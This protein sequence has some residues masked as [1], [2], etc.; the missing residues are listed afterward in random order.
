MLVERMARLRQTVDRLLPERHI[1]LGSGDEMRSISLSTRRQLAAVGLG[2]AVMVWAVG[3]TLGVAGGA[4]ALSASEQEAVQLK[5]R[6]QRLLADRQARLDQAVAQLSTT[7]G[8]VD[9]LAATVESRHEAL[10]KVMTELK[11]EPGAAEALEVE[12]SEAKPG[13][14]PAAR[15][16]RV[17]LDQEALMAKADAFART[18]AERLKLALRMA[19][20]GS[21]GVARTGVSA[22]GGP[23]VDAKD[24]RALAAIL[25]VDE[26]F[27]RRVQRVSRNLAE[28]RQLAATAETVP[29]AKPVDNPRLTSS[30]GVRFDPFTSTPAFHAGQDFG[31][32]HMTPVE[33]TAPGV[34]SYAGVR[35]GY[36]NTVEVDH[37]RGF[38]T[39]YAHLAR[40][41]VKPGQRVALGQSLGGMGSTG[42]STGTH[43][44]YEIWVN[45]R[46]QNPAKFLK[47][48][49][50][51]YD[52]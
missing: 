20:V 50:H 42:R 45:G 6:Y 23:L 27:A 30:F 28:M 52:G 46:V 25:D 39:R 7:R 5:A 4:V 13:A 43:L 14:T 29:L 37:G 2:A 22:L 1:H 32:A 9:Q 48:G 33:A 35:S 51:V 26:D 31:G 34:V 38:K 3:A 21:G 16:E 24:P 18:R 49:Q 10:A 36:G 40:I 15:I 12:T 17:R 11:T 19:G 8:S 41:H 47:A 44:H